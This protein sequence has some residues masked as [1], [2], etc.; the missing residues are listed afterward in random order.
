[1]RMSA[2][3]ERTWGESKAI[4]EVSRDIPNLPAAVGGIY[5]AEHHPETSGMLDGT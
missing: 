1:M 3:H 4:D 5:I 2:E